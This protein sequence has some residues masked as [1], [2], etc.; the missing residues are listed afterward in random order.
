M[1]I[2]TP[3]M[4][5]PAAIRNEIAALK[6]RIGELK[7]LLPLA[8]VQHLRKSAADIDGARKAATR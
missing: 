3:R 6:A 7:T 8:E 1:K 4:P 2:K 5:E